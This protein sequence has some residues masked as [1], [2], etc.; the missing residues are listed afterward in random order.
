VKMWGGRFESE[1]DLGFIEFSTSTGFDTRLYPYDIE[2]TRAWSSELK[3]VG[4][5]TA[6]EEA[7][8]Q[9]ALMKIEDEF[10][11]GT[12]EFRVS[13]EDI[14]TAV[15]RRLI[16]MVGEYA[17]KVRTG[18]SRNDQVATDL[19]LLVMDT[20]LAIV[21]RIKAVQIALMDQA[22]NNM[23]VSMPGHT[24]LQQ[25]QPVLLAHVLLAFVHMFERDVG[26]V[27]GAT[28]LAD[29]MP[30]GSGALAGTTLPI[31]RG[32]L[33]HSLGF[34][35]VSKNSVDAVSDRD[36]VC[37]SIFALGM[38]MVHLSRLSEQIVLWCSQE[39][40]IADLDDAWATGSS[41]MPQK[42]NPDGAELV[43]AKSGRVFG[44]LMAILAVLKG[45]PLS[46][47]RDLQEDKEAFF[48][49]LDTVAGCLMVIGQTVST[50]SF[51]K[52]KLAA[53]G[54]MGFLTA[55]DLAD[56]LVSKGVEF[57][58]AHRIVGEVVSFCIQEKRSLLELS[59]AEFGRFSS[60]FDA[61]VLDWLSVEAS[62][63]RRGAEGGTAP[64]EVRRQLDE[65]RRM[66][67]GYGKAL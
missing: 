43:R 7:S 26:L 2:C 67:S 6:E 38:V 33:A 13:D 27:E 16:E 65:A 15:E 61:D 32:R 39:F 23:D 3:E 47:N 48:D 51:D 46:Y 62:L 19:R 64:D 24:H 45:L 66:V 4:V 30:L 28:Q 20:S 56:Y 9:E 63:A 44:D 42:K 5:L 49:S 58:E 37:A 10:E 29:S 31:D 34:S 12:F 8:I 22:E 21:N 17:G 54:D 59:P 11:E 35:T 1:P 25:A 60:L 55:T 41:L 52:E 50:M 36:F 53:L 57:P 14:H 40:G 18:R